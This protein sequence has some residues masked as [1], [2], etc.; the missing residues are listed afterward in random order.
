M[1]AKPKTTAATT[2]GYY[3]FMAHGWLARAKRYTAAGKFAKARDAMVQVGIFT[4][5]LN[6][7]VEG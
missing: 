2:P 3:R 1:S 5:L 6:A 7:A 4:A